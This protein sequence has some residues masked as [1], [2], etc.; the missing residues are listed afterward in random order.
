MSYSILPPPPS[1]VVSDEC[2]PVI[3][4]R[5]KRW[6]I[7]NRMLHLGAQKIIVEGPRYKL[8]VVNIITLD[9]ILYCIVKTFSCHILIPEYD[10]MYCILCPVLDMGNF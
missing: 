10:T 6:T 5:N 1:S 2:N 4:F 9:I 3:F 7:K 8:G